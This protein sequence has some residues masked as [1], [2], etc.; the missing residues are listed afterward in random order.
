MLIDCFYKHLAILPYIYIYVTLYNLQYIDSLSI[1][2][3]EHN[4]NP[5]SLAST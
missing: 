2:V 5:V 1:V 3:S 4:H